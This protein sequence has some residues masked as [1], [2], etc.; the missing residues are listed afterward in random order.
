MEKATNN[1]NMTSGKFVFI[2]YSSRNQQS[3]DLLREWLKKNS[4]ASWMSPYD[5]PP[6]SSYAGVIEEAVRNCGVFC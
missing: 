6:G 1:I 5:I 2:S 4:I 3:A